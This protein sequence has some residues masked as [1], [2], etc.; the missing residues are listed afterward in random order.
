MC[1]R[2]WIMVTNATSSPYIPPQAIN[3]TINVGKW[4]L[5]GSA[6]SV[7]SAVAITIWNGRI[8]FTV[9]FAASVVSAVVLSV[10]GVLYK[11]QK[12]DFTCIGDKFF[13]R[14]L[15]EGSKFEYAG[16]EY[17]IASTVGDGACALHAVLGEKKNR[18]YFKDDARELYVIALQDKLNDAG[19]SE[20]W[21]EWMVH[22]VKD[23]LSPDPG[24]YSK[25]V[26]KKEL[27]SDLNEGLKQLETRE[28]KLKEKQEELFDDALGI[29][30]VQLK[31]RELVF[32]EEVRK[33]I[34]N[35]ALV[36]QLVDH[37]FAHAKM[38]EALEE[39]TL[40]IIEDD[41]GKAIKE[42]QNELNRIDEE[43]SECYRQCIENPEVLKAYVAGVQEK[44]Y[45]FSTQ[46]IGLMAYLFN[47]KITV[48]HEYSGIVNVVTEEGDVV[49]EEGAGESVVVFHKGIH[50]SRCELQNRL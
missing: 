12:F 48:F 43:R 10:L 31:L 46:E 18:S 29:E 3:P 34:T 8:S 13:D 17:Y 47:R 4:M 27:I 38:R 33:S 22:F 50:Y 15:G 41:T 36:N 23:Y 40:S 24:H 19:F 44:D 11:D 9:P 1:Y 42:N 32:G 14:S 28:K 21:K 20:K 16:Q 6:L 39:I 30:K 35:G 37:A 7:T 2:G 45:Y 5:A 25:L 26:F 49:T